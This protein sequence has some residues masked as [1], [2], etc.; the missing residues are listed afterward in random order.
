MPDERGGLVEA[1]IRAA[2]ARGDFDDLPGRGKPLDLSEPPGVTPEHRFEALL[3]RSAGEVAVEVV[4]AREIRACR[5]ALEQTDSAE[6]RARLQAAIYGKLDELS[7]AL[8]AR[9]EERARTPGT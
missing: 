9:R 4:L 1:R 8:K 5:K 3:L 7:A 2:Q 6:E